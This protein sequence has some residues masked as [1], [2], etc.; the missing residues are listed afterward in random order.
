MKQHA[1][2]IG[3]ELHARLLLCE[4]TESIVFGGESYRLRVV[5]VKGEFY[6]V[7]YRRGCEATPFKTI[8]HLIADKRVQPRGRTT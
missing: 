8:E 6:N 1:L 4:I 5:P 7:Y 3:G 2:C